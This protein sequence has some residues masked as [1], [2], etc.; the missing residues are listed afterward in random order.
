MGILKLL[1]GPKDTERRIKKLE[2][3]WTHSPTEE[4]QTKLASLANRFRNLVD[5]GDVDALAN[6]EACIRTKRDDVQ[7]AVQGILASI[8]RKEDLVVRI[9][10]RVHHTLHATQDELLDIWSKEKQKE[11]LEKVLIPVVAMRKKLLGIKSAD[12]LRS[13]SLLADQHLKHCEWEKAEPLLVAILDHQDSK[14]SSAHMMKLAKVHAM[15]KHWDKAERLL[16]RVLEGMKGSMEVDRRDKLYAMEELAKAYRGQ[17]LWAEAEYQ[18]RQVVEERASQKDE[19]VEAWTSM[20]SLGKL[21]VELGNVKEGKMWEKAAIK[22]KGLL[23]LLGMKHSSTVDAKSVGP[24]IQ[25]APL[26]GPRVVME[27]TKGRGELSHLR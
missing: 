10:H 20:D 15:Q 5:D 22:R 23:L 7:D 25:E 2:A 13:M 21:L 4:A 27:G 16:V 9:A 18:F 14:T 1:I 17:R 6:L 26:C 3:E 11:T 19:D 24:I 12:T 8:A